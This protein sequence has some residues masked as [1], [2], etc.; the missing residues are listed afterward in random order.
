M[1]LADHGRWQAVVV[2]SLITLQ[3]RTDA[4]TGGIVAAPTTSLPGLKGGVRNL[5]YRY[6]WLRD[7]ASTLNALLLTGYHEEAIARREWP[8]AAAQTP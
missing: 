5:D 3:A 4:P 1:R 6:C 8:T 7:A 2:R